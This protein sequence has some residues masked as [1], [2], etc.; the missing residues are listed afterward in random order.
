LHSSDE[1]WKNWT[2]EWTLT[3]P[4]LFQDPLGVEENPSKVGWLDRKLSEKGPGFHD[5]LAEDS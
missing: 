3:S 1:Q 2:L 4:K 5:A